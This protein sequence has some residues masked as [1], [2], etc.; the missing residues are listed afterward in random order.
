MP[1]Y[2]GRDK[3]N[4]PVLFAPRRYG[5][6]V[7]GEIGF[8]TRKVCSSKTGINMPTHAARNGQLLDLRWFYIV[9][10]KG[11][12][13]IWHQHGRQG[14]KRITGRMQLAD[15]GRLGWINSQV[16]QSYKNQ[17]QYVFKHKSMTFRDIELEIFTFR[18]YLI[19]Q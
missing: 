12:L 14:Q 17:S 8:A 15:I 16:P 6:P 19:K 9:Q 13:H 1:G 3:I 10:I 11:F 5:W 4:I 7:Y 2:I 18:G